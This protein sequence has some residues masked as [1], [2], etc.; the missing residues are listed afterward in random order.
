MHRLAGEKRAFGV[1]L[2]KLSTICAR[3]TLTRLP[4]SSSICAE[5]SASERMRPPKNLPLS[6]KSANMGTIFPRLARPAA[7]CQTNAQLPGCPLAQQCAA[8]PHG[9]IEQAKA[10]PRPQ[11][12]NT[13]RKTAGGA[14]RLFSFRVLFIYVSSSSI[15]EWVSKAGSTADFAPRITTLP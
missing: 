13:K 6:S 2:S 11:I 9:S 7:F 3:L 5:V 14:S 15:T 8:L 10:T 4:D 12:P 1:G